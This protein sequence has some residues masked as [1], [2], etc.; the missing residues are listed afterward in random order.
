MARELVRYAH[1]AYGH[2]L[3]YSASGNMS[4]REGDHVYIT[5]AGTFLG[6]LS[7][8]EV[9]T[10][11]INDTPPPDS[12]HETRMHLNCYHADCK[13]GAVFHSQPLHASLVYAG[14]LEVN[15]NLV[16]E[17]M[18]FIRNVGRVPYSHP[19]STELADA[20]GQAAK[21]HDIIVLTN[22]GLT[23]VGRDLN[24]VV[25][26]TMAFEFLCQTSALARA[27]DVKLNYMPDSVR[28]DL[29]E[30]FAAK[31]KKA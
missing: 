16:P 9:V 7:E 23:V 28:A 19:T 11:H 18:G 5:R 20:V 3:L 30:F 14:D 2:H 24:D 27:A 12:S 17:T 29:V 26:K 21:A 25:L 6:F 8:Q 31:M 15:Q 4:V 13:I 1:I 22:H 10:F